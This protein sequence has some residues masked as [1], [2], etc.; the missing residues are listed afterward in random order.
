MRR[1]QCVT[2]GSRHNFVLLLLLFFIILSSSSSCSFILYATVLWL[3]CQGHVVLVHK[4]CLFLGFILISIYF[5]CVFVFNTPYTPYLS[6]VNRAHIVSS[7]RIWG[8]NLI[9]FGLALPPYSWRFRMI[10]IY[11]YEH[12]VIYIFIYTFYLFSELPTFHAV[13]SGLSRHLYM[14]RKL[15]SS[16]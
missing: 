12:N 11:L 13:L 10:C 9:K 7:Y 5:R 8:E 6:R 4:L 15:R 3:E 1:V 2:F 16:L 14:G